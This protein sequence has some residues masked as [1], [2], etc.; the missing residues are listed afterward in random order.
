MPAASTHALPRRFLA[1]AGLVTGALVLVLAGVLA[2]LLLL[3]RPPLGEA[4]SRPL[5]G[6]VGLSALAAGIGLFTRWRK[7]LLLLAF[8]VLALTFAW[9]LAIRPTHDRD[10]APEAAR[11][12]TGTIAGDVLT[13]S[14]VRH[15]TW[16]T[17][18]RAETERWETRRY[19]LASLTSLDL[20]MNYWMGPHIAH[21][22]LSFG[23]ADGRHLIWSVEVRPLRGQVF[24]ALAGLFK[25][26]EL[27][28]IAGDERDLI[29]RR[30]NITQEDVRL[31]RL[32][33]APDVLRRLLLEYVNEAN[34]LAARPRFYNTLTTN[35]TNVIVRIT[36]AIGVVVP[37]DWRLLLNGHL[38]A[39][40]HA[41]GALLSDRPFAETQR[42]A[43]VTAR[44]AALP[45]DDAFSANLRSGL[46]GIALR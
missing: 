19:D 31:Y 18:D 2:A 8:P 12:P 24:D 43:A 26:N 41:R 35:C 11:L 1:G 45:D 6:A 37:A 25:T 33:V 15:F 13:L 21:G 10:W 5:A 38:P 34:G 29:R 4:I 20:V 16:A 44:A 36:R 9:W 14:N 42:L 30:T 17:V 46:P 32:K 39:Y 22:Q 3:Y 7:P 28:I 27:I 23:F 40:L